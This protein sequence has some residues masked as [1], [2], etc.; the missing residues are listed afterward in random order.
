LPVIGALACSSVVL[1]AA[2][3]IFMFNRIVFGG[4][5]SPYLNMLSDLNR[6]EF[7]MLFFLVAFTI[8][9][10]IY[11]APILDGLHY[12]VSTLIYSSN[13]DNFT[14]ALIPLWTITKT[15]NILNRINNIVQDPILFSL[16]SLTLLLLTTIGMYFMHD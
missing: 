1:S 5:Y 2:F 16:L 9:L 12:S 8:L 6:R 13:V 11:P 3:T 15:K 14:M 7:Y 4:Y 10:G